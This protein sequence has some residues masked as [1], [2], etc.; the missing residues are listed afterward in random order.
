MVSQERGLTVT[1]NSSHPV[2]KSCS[3]LSQMSS[4]ST[5]PFPLPNLVS[6]STILSFLPHWPIFWLLCLHTCSSTSIHPADKVSLLKF[7]LYHASLLFKTF[8]WLSLAVTINSKS[9]AY[10]A[11]LRPAPHSQTLWSGPWLPLQPHCPPI[12]PPCSLPRAQ[13]VII[14]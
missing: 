14:M 1:I 2:T 13:R 11:W 7:K 6:Q 12:P 5:C 8:P 9:L 10:L 4:L 3:F